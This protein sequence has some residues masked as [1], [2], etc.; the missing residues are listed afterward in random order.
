M[1]ASVFIE[2]YWQSIPYVRY[3][4]ACLTTDAMDVNE[5]GDGLPTD[6]TQTQE[7]NHG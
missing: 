1:N 6:L 4:R 7:Y 2:S 3:S 5:A